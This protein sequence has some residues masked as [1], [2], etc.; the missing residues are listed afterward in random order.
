MTSV[1]KENTPLLCVSGQSN[2]TFGTM[3]DKGQLTDKS[4][5]L[6]TAFTEKSFEEMRGS[7]LEGCVP[8]DG[9]AAGALSLLTST[10]TPTM[11]SLPLAFSVG[12]MRFAACCMVGCVAMTLCSVRFLAIASSSAQSDDYE[13]VAGHFFGNTCRWF[14][15]CVLFF[16]NFGCSVVYLRFIYDSVAPVLSVAAATLPPWLAGNNGPVIALCVFVLAATPLSFNSRLASLRTK[17]LLSNLLVVF[18]VVSIAYRYFVP[19]NHASH[20]PAPA[21]QLVFTAPSSKSIWHTLLPYFFAGPIFVFSYEVQSNV[22]SVFH[23]LHNPTS[24]RILACI[25]LS[26]AGAT[27][28]YTPVGYFGA[29]AFPNSVSGNV[30]INYDLRDDPLMLCAQLACCFSAAI[31]FVFVLFPC[32]FAFFMLISDGSSHKVPHKFRVRIGILLSAVSCFLAL[33]VPDVAV[34]VS[35]LGA[36]CSATLSMT[37]PSL[38]AME[39][40]KSGTYC[41]S[42]VDVITSWLMLCGG[43]MF[44]VIGTVIGFLL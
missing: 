20:M 16:Y 14:T 33:F 6:E 5:L 17:G 4:F 29:S 39:M 18:I 44:S 38:F 2:D 13:T 34:V 3:D 8:G 10:V 24:K 40:R 9:I 25:C 7:L 27:L 26:L 12:G 11:L 37:L 28:F 36:C 30:L 23:D 31:S 19:L 15:R 42:L 35:V 22:M 41:T 32:R 21:Q 1:P 43:V